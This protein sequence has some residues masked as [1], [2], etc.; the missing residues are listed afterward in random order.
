MHTRWDE[1]SERL[2]SSFWFVPL[3]MQVVS[4]LLA[5]L[6]LQIDDRYD[7]TLGGLLTTAGPIGAQN[8]LTTVAASMVTVGATVL[9]I[10]I[11][12]MQ[13]ASTQFGPRVLTNF[14]RDRVNQVALGTFVAV[15]VYAVLV[16]RR[17]GDSPD[18]LPRISVMVTMLLTATAVVMLIVF[19]HHIATNIQAMNL[20]QVV[21]RDVEVKIDSLFP[22]LEDDI[23]DARPAAEEPRPEGDG[24]PVHAGSTGYLQIIDLERLLA[25]AIEHD[26]VLRIDARPGKFIVSESSVIRVWAPGRLSDEAR[27]EIVKSFVTGSRRTLQQDVEFPMKQLVEMAVRALSPAINDPIT[28]NACVD[29][30]GAA[31]C[32]VAGRRLPPT[33]L[34]GPDGTPRIVLADPLTFE[35]L[36]GVAFDEIRQAADFHAVVYI[37]LLESLERAASCCGRAEQLDALRRQGDLVLERAEQAVAQ[38]ADRDAVRRRHQLLHRA[39]ERALDQA[40]DRTR[41]R[42]GDRMGA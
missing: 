23:E 6:T 20:V 37:H 36:V 34:A 2:R 35:R 4:A 24:E 17:T 40:G 19:M 11:V 31:L 39:L 16:L 13:L 27:D 29:H 30:L 1:L 22:D 18:S 28:A 14:V 25:C 32:Q 33:V 12:V 42:A 7:G 41:N 3:S 5:T 9:S 21:A 15:F 10:T 38:E 26:L 8:V